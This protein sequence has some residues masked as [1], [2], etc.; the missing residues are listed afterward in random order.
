MSDQ[1]RSAA[2]EPVPPDRP[3]RTARGFANPAS[4]RQPEPAPARVAGRPQPLPDPPPTPRRRRRTAT[5]TT[6]SRP[7]TARPTSCPIATGRTGRRPRP[8]SAPSCRKPQIGD[9][10]ARAASAGAGGGRTS[11]GRAAAAPAAPGGRR[12]RRRRRARPGRRRWRRRRRRQPAARRSRRSPAT[13]TPIELDEETLE[14]RQGRERKGRPVGRYL[15]AVHASRADGGRGRHPDR[16]AR[17]PR[18]HRALRVAPGRRRQPDPRQHLPRPGPERAARHGGGVR[19]HRHAEERRALPGRRPVRPRG[20]RREGRRRP[21]SSRSS[22]PARPS[23]ARSRRTRSAHK[24]A[25]L[26][27]E[28][29][30]PGPVR[31][32]DPEQHDLRHLQ[33]A[34]RRRAQAAALDPRQGQAEGARRHRAHRGRERHRRGDRARRHPAGRAVG[35]D[36]GAGR[37]ARRR[38]RCST[39]SPT[40][41]CG[42]SAR[43]STRTTARS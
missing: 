4:Q 22:R 25:R 35:A 41:P 2:A 3:E 19:R 38:R 39:A 16:G 11:P 18:A 10:H 8:P 33:A 1:D 30:L 42:S 36:R 37:Q 12:K 34:A 7:A 13:T 40:W 6:T 29:S 43:S 27:Q 20:R 31:R 28:V 15:M 17:G 14:Q 32:A 26:T 9:T 21:A 24:G 5:P 23:S